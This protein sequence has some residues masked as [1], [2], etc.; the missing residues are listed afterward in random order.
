MEWCRSIF[1]WHSRPTFGARSLASELIILLIFPGSTAEKITDFSNI[2]MLSIFD[3][4]C[5]KV[6]TT[7]G[8]FR[9]WSNIVTDCRSLYGTFSVRVCLSLAR[10]FIY[11]QGSQTPYK[12]EHLCAVLQF[13]AELIWNNI[14]TYYNL[15]MLY[16]RL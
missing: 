4:W 11:I 1:D 14:G 9:N 7:F 16:F 15:E 5:F 12:I 6:L 2:D 10:F 3:F 13:G 8:A